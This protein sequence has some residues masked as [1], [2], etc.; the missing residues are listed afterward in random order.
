MKILFLPKY[1]YLGASSRYRIL[2]YVEFYKKTGI[3]CKV[4]PMFS[5]GYIRALERN[6][7]LLRSFYL[8]VAIVRRLFQLFYIPFYN[9]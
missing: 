4:L 2:Q 8:F 9:S 7:N 5:D 1:D 3:V 6:N